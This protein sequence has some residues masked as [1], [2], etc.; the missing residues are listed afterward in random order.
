MDN[1]QYYCLE[2]WA[3]TFWLSIDRFQLVFFVILP[4]LLIIMEGVLTIIACQTDS[5]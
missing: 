2:F 3:N 5:V 1:F 4:Y